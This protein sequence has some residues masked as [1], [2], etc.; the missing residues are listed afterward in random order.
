MS[1]IIEF[2]AENFKKIKAVTIRP[3]AAVVPI[4]G[5]NRNGKTSV[6]DGIWVALG[7]RAAKTP[8]EP[9]RHG[10]ERAKLQVKIGTGE[11]VE[12][13][14]IR[15]FKAKEDGG[16][17]TALTVLNEHGAKLG[18]GQS[19]LNTVLGALTFDPLKFGRADDEERLEMLRP[20]DAAT[21]FA[22][23]T[24]ANKDDFEART[25]VN[26]R[27]KDLR[28]QAEGIG[29][30]P[31]PVPAPVD[32]EALQRDLEGA[33][34][35]NADI[36]QRK[37]RRAAA[38]REI[39][40]LEAE[41]AELRA[42]LENLIERRE[43]LQAK[44][45]TAETLPEAKDVAALGQKLRDAR[46]TNDH[47]DR[48]ARRAAIEADARKAEDEA[49]ALTR[50]IDQRDEQMAASV[51]KVVAQVPGLTFEGGLLRL[52][53]VP[54]DQGSDAEQLEA[55]LAI[56]AMLNPDLRIARVRDGSLLDE[57]AMQVLQATA[58]RLDLQVWIERVD[59]SGAVG[60]VMEDG[61]LK[62]PGT[63]PAPRPQPTTTTD[64]TE[65][66]I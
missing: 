39:E 27:A 5:K 41:E 2:H 30:P 62:G 31:G 1:Q 16:F 58:E 54:F 14:A 64:D 6:L 12:L 50:A 40:V 33:A 48:A 63:S 20:L 60:F 44:L 22:A 11:K 56:A 46:A 51:A 32:I 66:A 4:T 21:D 59:S 26:R 55:S 9:I 52:N 45:G 8:A 65:E 29:L 24:K 49:A 13:T 7:G 43:V 53:G 36:E 15:T 34:A 10:E 18:D 35:F 38:I 25:V 42:K 3:G 61:E 17:T 57:E 28:A 47:A 19:V 23:L 37:A